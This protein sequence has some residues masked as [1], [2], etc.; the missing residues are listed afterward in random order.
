M[1]QEGERGLC[2]GSLHSLLQALS[3]KSDGLPGC[4]RLETTIILQGEN[5]NGK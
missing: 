5:E 3:A 4:S 2:S 1:I